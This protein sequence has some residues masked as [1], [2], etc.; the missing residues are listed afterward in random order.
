MVQAKPKQCKQAEY[1]EAKLALLKA[2]SRQPLVGGSGDFVS[3][4]LKA[5]I[6][7]LQAQVRDLVGSCFL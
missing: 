1:L 3:S 2:G 4:S 6:R 7:V 5:S